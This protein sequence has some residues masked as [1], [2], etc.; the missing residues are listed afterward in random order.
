MA[1]WIVNLI[2]AGTAI[3][4]GVIGTQLIGGASKAKPI[5]IKVRKGRQR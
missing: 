5:A 2:V 3:G 1:T 4:I